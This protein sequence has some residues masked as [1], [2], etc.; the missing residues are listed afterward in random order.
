MFAY[1]I[2]ANTPRYVH[3]FSQVIDDIMPI[4]T[5][6]D[7]ERSILDRFIDQRRLVEQT[8]AAEAAEGA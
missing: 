4:P 2:Q 6:L 7:G 5:R 3:L 1:D 8:A